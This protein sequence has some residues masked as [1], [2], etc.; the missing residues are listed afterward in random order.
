MKDQHLDK[1]ILCAIY[2][3]SKVLGKEIKFKHIVNSYKSLPFASTCVYRGDSDKAQDTIIGFYNEFYMVAMKS[4]ILQFATDKIPPISPAP[5]KS[6]VRYSI[7]LN[8]S[9]S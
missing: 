3:I 1:M 6:S 8:F 7:P 2:A 5:I 4:T 9:I